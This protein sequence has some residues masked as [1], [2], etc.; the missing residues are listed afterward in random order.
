MEQ[1]TVEDLRKTMKLLGL[2]LS[3]ER[4]QVVAPFLNAQ[5]EMLQPLL[6][7]GL[8]KEFEPTSYLAKLR[9]A[10]R[11]KGSETT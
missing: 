5:L 3:E 2:S 10:G 11:A 7:L 8:P 9:E 4:L 1:L 6:N